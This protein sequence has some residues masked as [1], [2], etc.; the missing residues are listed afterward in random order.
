MTETNAAGTLNLGK[1]YL[2]HPGSCGKAIPPVTDVAIIDEDWNF[3]EEPKAVGE[4]V[5][6]SPANMVGYW[7]NQEATD[8]VF[9]DD[10]WFKS[11][12]L[13]YIDDGCLL[14]TSPSPRD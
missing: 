1:D 5:I 6:K 9:N 12:D 10:G 11:G 7:M 14:Y 8:E 13:G 2:S 3:I 4:I